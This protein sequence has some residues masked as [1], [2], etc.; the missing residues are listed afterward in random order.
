MNDGALRTEQV[1]TIMGTAAI[2][3][4]KATLFYGAVALCLPSG[5][6]CIDTVGI[7]AIMDSKTYRRGEE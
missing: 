5:R 1:D 2:R 4:L 7:F 3:N 6:R